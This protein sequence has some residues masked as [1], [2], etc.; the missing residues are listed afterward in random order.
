MGK[1]QLRRTAAGYKFDLKAANGETVATSEVYLSQAACVKGAQSVAK[2]APRAKLADLTAGQA[3]ASNPRFEL[4]QDQGG[5]Y[6]FRLKARNG[7][8]IAV[9]QAYTTRAA[10]TGGVESVRENAAQAIIEEIK[11]PPHTDIP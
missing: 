3:P 6:R 5:A 7:K 1:F 11:K 9:S 8:I 2:C 4:Y 10:C